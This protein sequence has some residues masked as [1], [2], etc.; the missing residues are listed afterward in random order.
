VSAGVFEAWLLAFLLWTGLALGCLGLLMLGHLLKES[1][2]DPLREEL[3]AGARTVPLT[4]LLALPLLFGLSELYPWA[5]PGFAEESMLPPYRTQYLQPTWVLIRAAVFFIIWVALALWIARPG[6]HRRA[7]AFGLVLLAAT[8]SVAA[9]D[10]IGSRQPEWWS[11][12]FGMAFGVNQLLGALALAIVVDLARPS[13]VPLHRDHLRGLAKTLLALA[14]LA[15]WLWFSQFLI[16]WFG[17]LPHEV[18]WYLVRR[19]GWG[20]LNLG[21][22]IPALVLAMALLVPRA[23]GR[24]RMMTACGLFLLHHFAYMIWLIRPAAADP[25]L[26]WPDP[27]AF[28]VAGLLWGAVFVYSLHTSSAVAERS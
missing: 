23:G 6:T 15:L 4:A 8:V 12:L 20:L 11:S 22:I 1:W 10:W 18:Q 19:N 7:S 2:V 5:Q 25:T 21:I 16:V 17:N 27:V 26:R 3:E 24:L 14:L 28:V 13:A 9:I